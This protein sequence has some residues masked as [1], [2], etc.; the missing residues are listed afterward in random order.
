MR[1]SAVSVVLAAVTGAV[2]MALSS[3]AAAALVATIAGNDC[4]GAFNGAQNGFSNCVI[5]ANY[6]PPGA[7]VGPLGNAATPVIIKFDFD[8]DE[9]Q[10]T[11]TYTVE[12]NKAL[13][14]TIDGT[15]FTITLVDIPAL[16]F[17]A[18]GEWLYTPNDFDDPNDPNDAFDPVVTFFAV[19]AGNQFD[20]HSNDGDPLTGDWLMLD[21]R[22]V[23]HLTFYDTGGSPPATVPEPGTL[24][25]IGG[26]LAALALRRR[27][28]T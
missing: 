4:P 12:I 25:L 11:Y 3:A 2:A 10:R 20:L 27:R 18:A 17:G 7:V 24:L 13:F 16:N 9:D 14:P 5:P 22:S 28:R 15:E 1:K 23:S 8:I 6:D 26:A 19:M 21:G